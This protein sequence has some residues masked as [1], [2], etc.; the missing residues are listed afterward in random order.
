MIRIIFWI[1]TVIIYSVSGL[2]Y[3]FGDG[4]YYVGSVDSVGRPEGLGKYHN[5]AGNLGKKIYDLWFR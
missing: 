5:S 2:K 4:S 3:N 1:Y